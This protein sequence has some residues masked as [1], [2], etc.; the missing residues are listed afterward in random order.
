MV[1]NLEHAMFL[2]TFSLYARNNTT[3]SVF[4]YNNV[5][6]SLNLSKFWKRSFAQSQE[7]RDRDKIHALTNF[8]SSEIKLSPSPELVREASI[9]LSV[10]IGVLA[11]WAVISVLALLWCHLYHKKITATKPETET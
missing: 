7:T 1:A 2:P 9:P 3:F 5:Y 4:I 6:L 10:F 8:Y 11:T